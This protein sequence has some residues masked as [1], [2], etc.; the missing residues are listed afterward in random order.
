M[1]NLF[2]LASNNNSRSRNKMKNYRHCFRCVR[3]CNKQNLLCEEGHYRDDIRTNIV[4]C[5]R[6]ECIYQPYLPTILM[7]RFILGEKLNLC[8][9]WGFCVR[10]MNKKQYFFLWIVHELGILAWCTIPYIPYHTTH[11][12]Y[13]N[14]LFLSD[15]GPMLETLD[16]T[17]RIGSTPTFLYFDLYLYSAYA[18]HYVYF[19]VY[20]HAYDHGNRTMIYFDILFLG[21]ELPQH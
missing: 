16:Y 18:A 1:L 19:I 8:N 9:L 3:V 17:I 12:P 14:I 20:I 5:S 7:V 6:Y 11:I 13:R 10:L 21:F 4:K 2:S 15:E